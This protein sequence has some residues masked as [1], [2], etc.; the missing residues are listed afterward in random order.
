MLP[1]FLCVSLY[2]LSAALEFSCA[3]PLPGQA[4]TALDFSVPVGVETAPSGTFEGFSVIV[5]QVEVVGVSEQLKV[6]MDT[7]S[8]LLAIC[9]SKDLSGL[10]FNG[11]HACATY[12]GNGALASSLTGRWMGPSSV[13][14][15]SLRL[16]NEFLVSMTSDDLDWCSFGLDGIFGLDVFPS[17]GFA[18]P[19]SADQCASP[20]WRPSHVDHVSLPSPFRSVWTSGTK[21]GFFLQET[22]GQLVG[23]SGV[24]NLT[25]ELRLVGRAPVPSFARDAVFQVALLGVAFEGGASVSGSAVLELDSGTPWLGNLPDMLIESFPSG[26]F[27]GLRSVPSSVST[28][29]LTLAGVDGPFEI[30]LDME[31][32]RER[33]ATRGAVQVAPSGF[34]SAKGWGISSLLGLPVFLSFFVVMSKE[35]IA[36]YEYPQEGGHGGEEE[37]GLVTAASTLGPRFRNLL[38][39]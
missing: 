25:R 14:S 21:F 28:L 7:G 3:Q 18:S 39:A 37:G 15:G 17:H 2:V 27:Q 33:E 20:A 23:G 1:R 34:E 22:G 26:S 32:L 4:G 36:F 35:E 6:V 5:G 38:Q 13:V 8:N 31:N 30:S 16:E 29:K 11:T 19:V 12:G 24:E 10:P 9:S